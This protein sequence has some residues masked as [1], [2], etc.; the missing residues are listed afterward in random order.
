MPFKLDVP[1]AVVP[2]DMGAVDVAQFALDFGGLEAQGRIAG[3][4]GRATQACRQAP[5]QR[6]RPARPADLGGYCRAEDHRC[7]GIGK[8]Q[9]AASW[10]FD[11]GAIGIDPF[12]L[13]LDDTHFS[14]SFRRGSGADPTGEFALRGDALDIARYIPPPDPASEPFVLPTAA[15]KALKFRG[16]VELEQARLDDIEMKGVTIRLLLDDQG[17]RSAQPAP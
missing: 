16:S 15:L 4:A 12:T 13:T 3:D 1:K 14:G 5:N 10:N 9:L 8:L 2:E 17:L 7:R 6:L 11:A